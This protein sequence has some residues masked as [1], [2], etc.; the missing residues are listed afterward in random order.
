MPHSRELGF[1]AIEHTPHISNDPTHVGLGGG[2]A[3][4]EVGEECCIGDVPE[5][6][7]SGNRLEWIMDIQ[8]CA[9]LWMR[10]Q[11]GCEI[12]RLD[13]KPS[14]GVDEKDGRL[15]LRKLGCREKVP[16]ARTGID[17]DR[18]NINLAQQFVERG[19]VCA[20]P[21]ICGGVDQIVIKKPMSGT[22]FPMLMMMGMMT[23]IATFGV[24]IW[25]GTVASD[26]WN[27]SIATE[28]NT[29]AAGS[30]LL[31]DLGVL[32]S[33]TAWLVPLKFVGM[34]LL[35]SGI[36]LALVTIVSALRFQASR[37][38]ELASLKS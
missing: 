24:S 37:L 20:V 5:R 6:I 14:A 33:V 38:A 3:G 36:A 1:F 17:V 19:C 29:A 32:N 26:Y 35:F 30:D 8:Q 34:A 11:V 16:I 27:H 21:C 9:C 22:L 23:L 28:L 13:H 25:L 2:C 18:Q 15:H 4:G 12:A 10:A 31:R 7:V